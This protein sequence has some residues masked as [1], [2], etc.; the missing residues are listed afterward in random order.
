MNLWGFISQ[1]SLVALGKSATSKIFEKGWGGEELERFMP[2]I[3]HL[4]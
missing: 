1:E 2:S 3:P 4:S